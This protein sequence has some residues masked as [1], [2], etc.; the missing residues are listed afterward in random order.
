MREATPLFMALLLLL[1]PLISANAGESICTPNWQ[2]TEWGDCINDY[3]TRMCWTENKACEGTSPHEEQACVS[4][5]KLQGPAGSQQSGEGIPQSLFDIT[6]TLNEQRIE[7]SKNL[8]LTVTMQNF[9]AEYVPT[10][11]IYIIYNEGG[12]GVYSDIDEKRVYVQ[13]DFIKTFDDLTLPKGDYTVS[14]TVQYAGIVEEFN[15]PF[16]I[17]PSFWFI[18]R[19]IVGRGF[20]Q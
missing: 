10:R 9:G 16:E 19:G 11:L 2:C 18:I 20:N 1:P 7:D 3:Q 8:A 15:Q 4:K 5:F 13:N 6:F 12:V 17:R 14:L